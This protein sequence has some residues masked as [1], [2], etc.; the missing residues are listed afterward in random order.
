VDWTIA[1][2]VSG[3]ALNYAF[4]RN[5]KGDMIKHLD[6]CSKRID[7]LEEKIFFLATGRTL[8]EALIENN[9]NKRR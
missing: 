9:K 2:I 6:K 5:F 3:I 8:K 1:A 4:M 7:Q